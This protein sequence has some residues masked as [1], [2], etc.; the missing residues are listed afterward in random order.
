MLKIL[1]E[2]PP[3]LLDAPAEQLLQVLG[4]PAAFEVPGEQDTPLFLSVLLHGNETSGWNALRRYLKL[5]P[6]PPRTLLIFIGNVFAAEQRLRTLPQQQDYNR[7][8][9][10]ATGPE[11]EMVGELLAWLGDREL[12][13]SVDLHNNTGHNPHYSVITD[14]T[15]ENHALAFLFSETAVYVE[16]PDSVKRQAA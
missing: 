4:G 14:L 7:I 3:G 13:A 1:T 16:E 6:R 2:I 8:W 15:P 9:K 5:N 10:D 12:F 11:A